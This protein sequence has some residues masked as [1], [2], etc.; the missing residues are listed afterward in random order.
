MEVMVGIEPA[1]EPHPLKP[2]VLRYMHAEVQIFIKNVVGEQRGC[3]TPKNRPAEKM[4]QA[5]EERCVEQKQPG[6][7][8]P[9][10]SHFFLVLFAPQVVGM[11]GA[12]DAMMDERMRM[13]RIVP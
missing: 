11:I 2:A 13:E 9:G 5:Q 6:C 12:E 1:E 4:S 7:V 8:P 3:S 10:K